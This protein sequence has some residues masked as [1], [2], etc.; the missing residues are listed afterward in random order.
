M[1]VMITASILFA[2]FSMAVSELLKNSLAVT[3]IIVGLFVFGQLEVIPP[4][5]RLLSHLNAMLPSNQ[6]SIWSLA[7]YR[8]FNVGGHYFTGYVMSPVIYIVI[9]A[10]LIAAG[11]VSY[12]RFQVTGR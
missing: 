5:Y 7:E 1:I 2:A 8:L 10:V 4:Q 3:G 11:A 12:N 9:S 6:I